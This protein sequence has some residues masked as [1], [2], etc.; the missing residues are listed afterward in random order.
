M[1][2]LGRN[3][4]C[5]GVFR[6]FA[7]AYGRTVDPESLRYHIRSPT[8]ASALTDLIDYMDRPFVKTTLDFQWTT[9]L[10]LNLKEGW[11]SPSLI[12]LS[13]IPNLGV[14]MIYHPRTAVPARWT[15]A[16]EG[17]VNDRL[18]RAWADAAREAG[19][20]RMLKVL[21]CINQP[22]LTTDT[23]NHISALPALET[24]VT[25]S[26]PIGYQTRDNPHV[27]GWTFQPNAQWP[28]H[29]PSMPVLRVSVG[30]LGL[31]WGGAWKVFVRD[32]KLNRGAPWTE[33]LRAPRQHKP[34]PLQ[35]KIKNSQS[36]DIRSSLAD[37]GV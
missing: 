27:G 30:S 22:V 20:F 25:N 34:K 3:L 5:F 16:A 14:L 15:C 1:L 13:K 11:L 24:F 28:R 35:K 7:Q 26:F 29:A 10:T 21:A 19:A 18:L 31:P 8:N 9:V 12:D 36:N 6:A 32:P 33:A 17:F 23:F 2:N 37:F 4:D